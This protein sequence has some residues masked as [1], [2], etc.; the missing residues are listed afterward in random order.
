MH[1]GQILL[2]FPDNNDFELVFRGNYL[3]ASLQ[4]PDFTQS[5][6]NQQ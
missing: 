2:F 6:N 5:G 1:T 3:P 4:F